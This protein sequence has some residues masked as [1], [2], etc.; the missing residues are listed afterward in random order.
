MMET[1]EQAIL[2]HQREE[3]FGA[4]MLTGMMII[5]VLIIGI[6]HFMVR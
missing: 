6:V 3:R 5:P 2:R 1:P 4:F